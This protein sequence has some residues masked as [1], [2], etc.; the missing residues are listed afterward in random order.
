MQLGAVK[1]KKSHSRRNFDRR[2]SQRR[3]VDILAPGKLNRRKSAK[4]DRRIEDR[5]DS[6]LQ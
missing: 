2:I 3:I 5:R 1:K 4:P 6:H